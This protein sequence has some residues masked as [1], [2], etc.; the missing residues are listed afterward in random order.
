MSIPEKVRKVLPKY[1]SS[2]LE[3][4]LISS[5]E[6]IMSLLLTQYKY[7]LLQKKL[8]RKNQAVKELDPLGTLE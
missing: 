2:H 3:N 7:S 8:K 6:T 4:G 5:G 1:P